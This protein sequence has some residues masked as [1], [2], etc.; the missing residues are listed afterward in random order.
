[1][2]ISSSDGV[3]QQCSFHH[4]MVLSTLLCIKIQSGLLTRLFIILISTGHDGLYVG[5]SWAVDLETVVQCSVWEKN[6]S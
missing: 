2:F 6:T 4:L 1:M 5:L 3:V